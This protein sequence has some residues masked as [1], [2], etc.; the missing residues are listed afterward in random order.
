VFGTLTLTQQQLKEILHY[1]PETGIWTWRQAPSQYMPQLVGQR[2]GSIGRDGTRRIQINGRYYYAHQLAWFYMTGK[3]PKGEVDH[4]NHIQGDNRWENLRESDSHQNSC[5]RRKRKNNTSGYKGVSWRK[6]DE[7]WE[8][9]IQ[10]NGKTIHP[11]AFKRID[12]AAWMYDVAAVKYH[13]KF[14][15]VNF[16]EVCCSDVP[17]I[18]NTMIALL[19]LRRT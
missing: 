17:Y 2:A 12:F 5:N 6:R 3:W 11:G 13:G 7:K 4:R 15:V 9:K 18:A 14:A 1:E 10:V 8:T 19:V 16:P